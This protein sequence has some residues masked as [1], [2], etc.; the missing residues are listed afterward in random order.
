MYASWDIKCKGQFFV[1]S[2]H[3]LLFDPPKI[4]KNQNFEKMYGSWDIEH[5]RQFFWTI[6]CPFIP[7]TTQ[8][9]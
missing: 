4:P 3:F 2:G 7:Q 1:I 5:D 6:F 8:K 9:I